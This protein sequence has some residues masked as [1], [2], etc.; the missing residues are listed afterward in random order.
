MIFQLI[1]ETII[2]SFD[3]TYKIHD[4]LIDNY[5]ISY[6]I[7]SEPV[8]NDLLYYYYLYYR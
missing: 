7:N 8:E 6:P 1:L 5:N 4:L 2:N 3:Y